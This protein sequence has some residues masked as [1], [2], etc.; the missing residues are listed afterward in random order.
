MLRICGAQQMCF[1]LMV[2]EQNGRIGTADGRGLRE[3]VDLLK[4]HGT[5]NAMRRIVS[6]RLAGANCLAW[7]NHCPEPSG[8]R[9]RCAAAGPHSGLSGVGSA[10]RTIL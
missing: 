5:S 4:K 2:I 3:G 9:H 10:V 6:D 1:Y 8:P 7:C